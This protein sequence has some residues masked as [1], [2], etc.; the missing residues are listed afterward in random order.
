M[1]PKMALRI[2]LHRGDADLAAAAIMAAA[3]TATKSD[4]GNEDR[5][6][7]RYAQLNKQGGRD[8]TGGKDITLLTRNPVAGYRIAG[9]GLAES[10]WLYEIATGDR[11]HAA[12][13]NSIEQRRSD[14]AEVAAP[15]GND[16]VFEASASRLAELTHAVIEPELFTGVVKLIAENLGTLVLPTVEPKGRRAAR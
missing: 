2:E 7:R 6:V 16:P 8:G 12:L 13:A 10:L 15:G 5:F 1:V 3:G 14:D 4:P 11:S 9:I